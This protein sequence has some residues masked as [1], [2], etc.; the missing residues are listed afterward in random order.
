M[1][2]SKISALTAIVSVDAGTDVIPIVDIS[3]NQT[4]KVTRNTLLGLSSSPAGLDDA[5]VFTNKTIG[6]TN[7]LTLLDTLFTLQDNS[8]NTKQAQFQLSGITTGTTRT[9]TLPNASSTLVDLS[10]AQTLT[11]KVLTSPT[12]N[13]ATIS[14]PTL[15]TDTVSEYTGA[16]GVTIDGVLLKDSKMNASYLTDSSIT[17]AQLGVGMVAQVVSTGYAAVA[18]GTTTIPYDD[19]IPQNTEGIEFMTQAITPKSAT[20]ILVIQAIGVLSC[21]SGANDVMQMALFQDSTANA[22][23]ATANMML[24]DSVIQT[25]LLIHSMVAGTTSSTTFKIRAGSNQAG[26]TTF[27]GAG[28]TRLYGAITKSSI[29]VTEYKAS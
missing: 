6:I 20:N 16:A 17:N 7:T 29:V 10:T 23:A 3:D 27:N 2:D 11:N 22:L 18:T 24:L 4:K 12:I 1:A 15:T 19:T 21:S 8:D 14:N 26:T 28:G 9:Y 13:T 5:Q 25:N